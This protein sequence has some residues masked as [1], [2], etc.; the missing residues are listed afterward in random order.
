[1]KRGRYETKLIPH[2][3]APHI[4]MTDKPIAARTRL[5]RARKG[6]GFL[7][8]RDAY[9][10][11][12]EKSGCCPDAGF[13]PPFRGRRSITPFDDIFAHIGPEHLR[14]LYRTVRALIIL[15]YLTEYARHCDGG[16]VQ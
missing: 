2:T 11:R 1:M 3:R 10:E 16:V 8:S 4:T 6:R 7:D 9:D 12:I 15:Y 13:L 5:R 14:N